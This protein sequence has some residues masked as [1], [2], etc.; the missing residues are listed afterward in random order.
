VNSTAKN[1]S[2]TK[3]R[4]RKSRAVKLACGKQAAAI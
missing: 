4:V 2:A 3:E 1:G